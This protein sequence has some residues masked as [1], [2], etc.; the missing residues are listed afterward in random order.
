MV[1]TREEEPINQDQK[2]N[3]KEKE[4]FL[5]DSK[6]RYQLRNEKQNKRHKS[7][8]VKYPESCALTKHSNLKDHAMNFEE[9]KVLAVER[10]YEKRRFR[11]MFHI[12][13]LEEMI[14]KKTDMNQ[15]SA[16]YTH[17][18]SEEWKRNDICLGQLD[19]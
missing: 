13:R 12:N 16:I 1:N 6:I 5:A 7:D 17:L 4:H 15:L 2:I 9:A 18:I 11:E 8:I 14:N 19:K 3:E 10:N